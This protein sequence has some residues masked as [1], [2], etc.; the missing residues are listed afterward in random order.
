MLLTKARLFSAKKLKTLIK[1]TFHVPL[2]VNSIQ[3]LQSEKLKG[4]LAFNPDVFKKEVEDIMKDIS[5][6]I[7][8]NGRSKSQTERGILLQIWNNSDSK[9]S[10]KEFYQDKKQID[11]D[12]LKQILTKQKQ[13]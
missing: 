12:K 8:E 6:G 10:F 2:D 7:D 4:Y 11:I 1:L 13:S 9:K 3:L 5:I